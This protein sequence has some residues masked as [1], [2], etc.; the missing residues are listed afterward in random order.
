MS[1]GDV[2]LNTTTNHLHTFSEETES[3]ILVDKAGVLTC[4]VH[5]DIHG[6]FTGS[7]II[8]CD[9]EHITPEILDCWTYECENDLVVVNPNSIHHI[10]GS[11]AVKHKYQPEKSPILGCCSFGGYVVTVTANCYTIC[12]LSDNATYTHNI[13]EIKKCTSI[14][15]GWNMKVSVDGYRSMKQI[16]VIICDGNNVYHYNGEK[17]SIIDTGRVLS[18]CK[19]E[20]G[21]LAGFET[22]W[23]LSPMH[24]FGDQ[25]MN[26][27]SLEIPRNPRSS[28]EA[29]LQLYDWD[30]APLDSKSLPG[31]NEPTLLVER[32][33]VVCVSGFYKHVIS[34]FFLK[35]GTINHKKDI[36]IGVEVRCAGITFLKYD[37]L[38]LK[39]R[40]DSDNILLTFPSKSGTL[41]GTV[42]LEVVKLEDYV[43]N[44]MG[45][46]KI[47]QKKKAGYNKESTSSR[48]VL[49]YPK[50]IRDNI[51]EEEIE[52]KA[53]EILE[54]Y[55]SRPPRNGSFSES[56]LSEGTLE[57]L[58]ECKPRHPFIPIPVD[59]S[60]E[61][62]ESEL[63]VPGELVIP[64]FVD[65]D[66]KHSSCLIKEIVSEIG[67][68]SKRVPESSELNKIN[69]RCYNA[70]QSSNIEKKLDKIVHLLEKQNLLL[71]MLARQS[72]VDKK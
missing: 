63:V 52:Q 68:S 31:H 46:K 5:T 26:L 28:N 21:Y 58:A 34:I 59:D 22:N 2:L 3:F 54:E 43:G 40:F 50:F 55:R 67:E 39:R 27:D 42:A 45:R 8:N 70:E 16:D 14:I 48:G 37:L 15:A 44:L 36:S 6:H 57:I 9:L 13:T 25:P 29:R 32:R 49:S 64:T 30:L 4:T 1:V 61:G 23:R 51:T 47:H 65:A 60:S 71:E 66:K 19:T 35:N 20:F 11:Q 72:L 62:E 53:Q 56:E 17:G 33:N 12:N 10:K 69:S 18:I 24:L 7:S 41:S 38:I